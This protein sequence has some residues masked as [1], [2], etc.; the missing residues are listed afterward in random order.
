MSFNYLHGGETFP[1]I[2]KNFAVFSSVCH[3][4]PI[5]YNEQAAS[6][7]WHCQYMLIEKNLQQ[8]KNSDVNEH[9]NLAYSR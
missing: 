6:N 7:E 4:Q 2:D 8:S 5:W 3:F 9:A 1:E